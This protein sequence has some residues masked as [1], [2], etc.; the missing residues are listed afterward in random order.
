MPKC[1]LKPPKALWNT[2]SLKPSDTALTKPWKRKSENSFR[3]AGFLSARPSP[4]NDKPFS[5]SPKHLSNILKQPRNP[6][7]PVEV[8][9]VQNHLAHYRLAFYQELKGLC[10]QKQ[11][12]LSL[13][14]NPQPPTTHTN[15]YR[16][17]LIHVNTDMAWA[18]KAPIQ[19]RAGIGWQPIIQKAQNA[20]L[21][22]LQQ[23]LKYLSNHCLMFLRKRQGKKTALW[24]HG[25]NFQAPAKSLKEWVKKCISAQADWWFSYTPLST[26]TLLELPYPPER[27]TTV[28]NSVDT[29][30]LSE[31]KAQ[32]SPEELHRLR[33]TL[34]L[35]QEP[36]AIF[37]GGLHQ[38]KRIPFLIEACH[39]I[40]KELPDF[41]LL[42]I[43]DGPEKTH[44]PPAPWIKALGPKNDQ[45]K[46]PYWLLAQ[47]LL[48]PGCM[49]LAAVDSLCLQT[50]T[51]TTDYPFHSPEICYLEDQ[52]T[53]LV[54]RPYT[55][56]HAFAQKTISL[57]K[58]KTLLTELKKNCGDQAKNYSAQKMAGRFFEGIQQALAQPPYKP[59]TQS[60]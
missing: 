13:L 42:V 47:V 49:G 23:E 37:T 14:Y 24:G 41:H 21:V 58:N 53:C 25:R 8:L 28:L 2:K 20:Q 48:M 55:D 40:K 33:A 52:K 56:P 19:W 34:Q 44:I 4:P 59:R 16:S 32:T 3:W 6:A 30:L 12:R 50:P 43:G 38:F 10:D 29:A 60:H 57:L 5:T 1:Y 15:D 31:R 46:V 39:S 22:I 26:K 35:P 54:S 7:E 36:V 11:I 17:G 9:I 51:V 18:K 45:E 27:I